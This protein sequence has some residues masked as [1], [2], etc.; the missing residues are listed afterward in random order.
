MIDTKV[1][2]GGLEMATPL[3]TASGT[4]GYGTEYVGAV[5][6]A[7]L[8]AVTA[9]GI[10]VDAWPGNPMPRH[11][12]VPGGLVNAIGLQGTGVK[13][14]LDITVPWY[15]D[16]VGESV[17]TKAPP[18]IV[19]IWGGSVDEYAEVARQL[20]EYAFANPGSPVAA[21]ECNVSCPN[22]KAG[23][24]TFGQD[25]AVLN[26]LVAAVRKAT[27]LPLIVKLA[28]NVPDIRP[29]VKAC[30]DAGADALA[31]INTIPAMVID[32]EKRKP[33]LAN[34]TGGLSGRGIHPAA[35]KVVYDAY[36]AT[37]LPILAMGGVYEAK[38]AIE[39][40]LAGATAV[41]LG[42]VLFTDP[43]AVSDV[44]DGMVSY[45]ERHG[46]NSMS[47]LTGALEG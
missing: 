30:E 25:P 7:K 36:R 26:G 38:D 37:K 22:V 46:F 39:F 1:N 40:M 13:H 33:V 21:L 41:A 12:E 8:G 20:D 42:T 6:Y 45:C 43:G 18:M 35:V 27:S 23:G 10:R 3:T 34:R 28:P 32:I 19:N 29:Y 16:S 47:E 31:L 5:D 4:F 17:G 11:C 14:F 9:K 24:H 2:L 44:Y 15:A